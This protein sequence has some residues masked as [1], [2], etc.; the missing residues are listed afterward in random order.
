MRYKQYIQKECEHCKI[1]FEVPPRNHK[2]RFCSKRC[3]N[4]KCRWL[5]KN[6]SE[7]T[8]LKISQ[9]KKGNSP[10]TS[11]AFKKGQTPW[12]KGKIYKAILGEN[13]PNWKGGV[14]DTNKIIRHS[15]EYNIWRKAVYARDNWTCQ[16]CKVK[17]RLPVAHH[18]KTFKDYPELRFDV[19]NGLT[20]CR[21][22]HK[23][24]HAEIGYFTRFTK[25]LSTN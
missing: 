18:I 21:S 3:A 1:S 15:I 8:N 4:V 19:D 5:G 11:G 10:V 13:H 17:Q 24:V 7:E 12:N 25:Q 2:Q 20:L 6:R 14:S 22:C 9:T 23:K 16:H